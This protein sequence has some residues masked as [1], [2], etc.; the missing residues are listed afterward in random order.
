MLVHAFLITLAQPETPDYVLG[1]GFLKRIIGQWSGPLRSTSSVGSF[2]MWYV[3]YRPIAPN[4]VAQFSTLKEDAYTSIA[5]FI[6]KHKGQLK[7]AL[8]NEGFYKGNLCVTYEVIKEADDEAGY[9]RFADFQAA[10]NRAYTEFFFEKDKLYMI[11]R[12]TRFNT[13]FPPSMHVEW[14]AKLA[15]R[16]SA[17]EAI[18]HFKFPQPVAAA[19][20]TTAFEK[21]TDAVVGKA[22]PGFSRR[23]GGACSRITIGFPQTVFLSRK[24]DP[25]DISTF[26]YAGKLEIKVKFDRKLKI[27]KKW[28]TLICLTTKPLFESVKYKPENL[29]YIS[30][31]IYIPVSQKKAIMKNVH[32]GQYYIYA[33]VDVDG[34]EQ[35]KK[36]D[37]MSS[38]FFQTVVIKPESKTKTTVVVDLKIP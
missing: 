18:E 21:L 10:E 15:T 25:F 20:F 4:I 33:F 38:N 29:K 26:P 9:Y 24:Y 2:K 28:E 7:V 1:F 16:E 32:P 5:F 35:Y 22:P 37:Y 23:R 8:R 6:V 27:N 14:E 36:G 13:I 31:Y 19:D 12:T 30:R 34:D 11:V 17:Q 3:D